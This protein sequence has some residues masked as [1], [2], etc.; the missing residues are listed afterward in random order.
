MMA[1]LEDH[2]TAGNNVPKEVIDKLT[3]E[4]ILEDDVVTRDNMN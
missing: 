4:F 2:V 1:H 3:L